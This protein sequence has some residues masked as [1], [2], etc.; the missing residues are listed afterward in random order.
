MV[1]KSKSVTVGFKYFLGAHMGLVHG[2]VDGVQRIRVADKCVWAGAV[3]SGRICID[4]EEIF[5]G[6]GA[7]G[8]IKG[9]LVF[10]NGEPTQMPSVY[11]QGNLGTLLPAFRGVTCAILE[12]PY[13]SANNPYLK[14]WA[15]KLTRTDVTTRGADQWY[16]EKAA[17]FSGTR[18]TFGVF[19]EE[20]AESATE[21]SDAAVTSLP[22]GDPPPDYLIQSEGD[23]RY[24]STMPEKA[25]LLTYAAIRGTINSGGL[26]QNQ[27]SSFPGAAVPKVWLETGVDQ[28]DRPWGVWISRNASFD[29][30]PNTYGAATF[31]WLAPGEEETITTTDRFS[32][33]ITSDAS[34]PSKYNSQTDYVSLSMGSNSSL[35]Q[36]YGF[37][38]IRAPDPEPE[39]ESED[40]FA[41]GPSYCVDM[42]PAHIIRECLTDKEWGM[43][44]ADAD[45]DGVAFTAAADTLST[46]QM[47]ISLLWQRENSIEAFVQ[48]I[49]RHIDAA[50]YVDR[51]TGK[52]VLKLIRADYDAGSLITLGP[53]QIERVENYKRPAFG[54]LV[55]SVTVVYDDCQD[56]K[57]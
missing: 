50:L 19:D 47:G 11:L 41:C 6:E 13:I 20:C 1:D 39:V 43:G 5:G 27:L 30:I 25:E 26:I 7:E 32:V 49:V 44:Y 54:D 28:F 42:N 24:L 12:Q 34:V 3:E 4:A 9:E 52:F 16:K 15:F 21:D 8:G 22:A 35:P 10:A 36:L 17:I 23:I 51:R 40:E 57:N 37:V 48:E 55:N 46:E 56:G 29:P 18:P 33:I 53:N 45:I 31:S 2:P 38:V 14:P